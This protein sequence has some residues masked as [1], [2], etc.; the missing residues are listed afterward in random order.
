M[1]ARTD[2]AALSSSLRRFTMFC[3]IFLCFIMD[4]CGAKLTYDRGELYSIGY[5]CRMPKTKEYQS[6]H[7]IPPNI[8]RPLDAP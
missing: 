4:Y 5:N 6:S 1:A 3:V 2:A 7:N 8:A